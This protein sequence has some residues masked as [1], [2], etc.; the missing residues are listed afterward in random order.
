MIER[1]DAGVMVCHHGEPRGSAA[2][3]LCRAAARAELEG[4]NPYVRPLTRGRSVPMPDYVRDVLAEIKSRRRPDADRA[5]QE[6]LA[7]WDGQ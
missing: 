3:A 4:Q 5:V 1:D 7:E 6:A 2:C